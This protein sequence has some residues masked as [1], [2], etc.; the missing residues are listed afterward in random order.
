[1]ILTILGGIFGHE[2]GKDT[3][4]G[5]VTSTLLFA[6]GGLIVDLL[7]AGVVTLGVGTYNQNAYYDRMEHMNQV[8]SEK[9]N[10]QDTDIKSIKLA[11]GDT[12]EIL[13]GHTAEGEDG[14]MQ[15]T[16]T[17]LVTKVDGETYQYFI[18]TTKDAHHTET[19]GIYQLDEYY[20]T[21]KFYSAFET[22]IEN[23]EYSYSYDIGN[24]NDF[25]K[26]LL[27]NC[28][29]ANPTLFTETDGL[30]TDTE[31]VANCVTPINVSSVYTNEDSTKAY[32]TISYVESIGEN[33]PQ[34]KTAKVT[35]SGQNLTAEGIYD[36]FIYDDNYRFSEISSYTPTQNQDFTITL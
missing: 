20:N 1:M 6:T 16:L 3:H 24:Y 23:S 17:N 9:Y 7:I 33:N 14:F 4:E 19:G 36:S 18:D 31:Y 12:C 32:F 2:I 15:K 27:K 35:F 28:L 5:P 10:Y 22:L 8:V 26:S 34:I 30:F 29:Y 21:K 25:T 13:L 11:N